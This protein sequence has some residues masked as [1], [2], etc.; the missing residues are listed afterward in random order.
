KEASGNIS[1]V[2]E[3]LALAGDALDVYSGNDDQIVPIMSLG[4]KGVI[5]VLSNPLPKKTA[6]M[7]ALLLKGDYKAGAKLQ[8]ELLPLINA[9]FCQVNPIPAKAAMSA[10]G[11]GENVLRLPLTALEEQYEEKLFALLREQGAELR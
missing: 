3:I 4:G 1:K 9:L 5:S 8:L 2:A 7:T 10:M 11:Y 6:E